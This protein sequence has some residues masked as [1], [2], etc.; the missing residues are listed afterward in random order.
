MRKQRQA[1]PSCPYIAGP[2]LISAQG[3][4]GRQTVLNQVIDELKN[5]TA[6]KHIVLFGQRRIGKT[7][8]L[9]QIRRLLPKRDF[10][11]VFFNLQDMAKKPLGEVLDE[12]A[13]SIVD[14]AGL[15]DFP[16]FS[17][18]DNEVLFYTEFLP[19]LYKRIPRKRHIVL[20]LDEFDA[21]DEFAATNLS[22]NKAARAFFPFLRRLMSEE[23]RL[24]FV[25]AFGR[26]AEDVSNYEATFKGSTLCPIWVLDE[27]STRDLILQAEK[28]AT[29][30]FTED[31]IERIMHLTRGHPYFTQLICERIW[32]QVRRPDINNIPT[33][34]AMDVEKAIP[35]ALEAGAQGMEWLWGEGGLSPAERIYSSALAEAADPGQEI[36]HAN[37]VR[38]LASHTTRGQHQ[39][40]DSARQYL[41][42]RQILNEIRPQVY[43][44][45]IEFFHLWVKKH[46]PLSLVKDELDKLN[47]RANNFFKM[48]MAVFDKGEWQEAIG[49]F[50]EALQHSPTHFGAQLNLGLA[51]QRCEKTDDAILELEKAYNID[52]EA[53]D[54]LVIALLKRAEVYSQEAKYDAA[55][56]VYNHILSLDPSNE[57][58]KQGMNI[59]VGKQKM[60]SQPSEQ[61]GSRL[62]SKTVD[63][64]QPYLP[65]IALVIQESVGKDWFLE[66]NSNET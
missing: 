8:L 16:V 52:H 10:L 19:Q 62:A 49:Y 34:S 3:F 4:W 63:A 57:L 39:E 64:L 28:N 13:R 56:A 15:K 20:L 41:V 51:L 43:S 37:V 9:H 2:P 58:A 66:A 23:E 47:P 60:L 42:K 38:A 36:A 45:E 1:L 50:R 27:V 53:L 44:F 54:E 61:T 31:A 29:L 30:H 11:T 17:Y 46:K 48:G 5:S 40:V 59:V 65:L 14:N 6:A 21:L 24:N 22:D 33:V 18:D 26:Q 7:S 25:C 55:S 12:L 32:Y 35:L